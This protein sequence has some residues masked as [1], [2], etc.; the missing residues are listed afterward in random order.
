MTKFRDAQIDGMMAATLNTA[1]RQVPPQYDVP[2]LRE[3]W[4]REFDV[5]QQTLGT[6]SPALPAQAVQPTK[7]KRQ[8]VKKVV[9]TDHEPTAPPAQKSMKQIVSEY[10]HLLQTA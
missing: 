1:I 7:P 5:M 4:L 6:W 8:R 9:K 2:E 10:P 3:A